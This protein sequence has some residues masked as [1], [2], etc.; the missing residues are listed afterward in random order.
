MTASEFLHFLVPLAAAARRHWSVAPRLKHGTLPAPDGLA[1]QSSQARI[2]S[3]GL[4]CL[5]RESHL[6]SPGKQRR[7]GAGSLTDPLVL[8][9]KPLFLVCS[10]PQPP[11]KG[12]EGENT[13]LGPSVRDGELIFG[14]CH[15][16][17]SF[18][19]TF[20]VRSP[21]FSPFPLPSPLFECCPLSR[22][23]AARHRSERQG[24]RVSHHRRHEGES[25]P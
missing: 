13:T 22:V 25:R 23:A 24:D 20:V 2:T 12:A 10:P 11:K 8:S 4:T 3:P 18:N 16:F 14:V 17:A 9:L 21:A 1:A 6:L 5:E 19:D 15:I 7:R